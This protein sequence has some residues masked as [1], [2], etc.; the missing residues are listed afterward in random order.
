MKKRYSELIKTVGKTAYNKELIELRAEIEEL[1]SL[2][3]WNDKIDIKWNIDSENSF[4]AMV[5]WPFSCEKIKWNAMIVEII[6]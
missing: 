1:K 4:S 6:E 5:R 3:I 2:S